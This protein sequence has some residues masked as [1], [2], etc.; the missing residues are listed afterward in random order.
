MR[1]GHRTGRLSPGLS[2]DMI[3][4]DR[5]LM[6]IEPLAIAQTRVLATWFEGR[7]VHGAA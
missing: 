2:A 6:T 7:L 5:D 4:L 1:L 3:M